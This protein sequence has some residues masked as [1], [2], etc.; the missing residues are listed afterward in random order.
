MRKKNSNTFELLILG[1]SS[2]TPSKH[3]HPSAQLL[4]IQEQLFLIDCGE[5]TQLRLFNNKIHWNQLTHIFITHLHGDHSFGLPGLISSLGLYNREHKLT[6]VGPEGLQEFVQTTLRL[7]QS[8]VKFDL[9]F[10]T[11]DHR[12]SQEILCDDELKIISFP[13]D[14]RIPCVGYC[15]R[16]FRKSKK[17]SK[18]KIAPYPIDPSDFKKLKHGEE[19]QLKDEQILKPSDVLED[20]IIEKSFAYCSDTRYS[21]SIL[22][23]IQKVD[24]LYHETTYEA[25]LEEKAAEMGHSTTHQAATIASKA[26]VGKLVIGHYSSRYTELQNLLNECQS[27]FPKTVLGI[28]DLRIKF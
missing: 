19:V 21:E 25:A 14:H 15:F 8:Q 23:Y 18:E 7:S 4:N 22:P 16:F 27:V 1:T 28:E 5:A 2:A 9:E 11:V 10:I 6:L 3:R 17:L 26:D 13:L 12:Q 24:L 20:K